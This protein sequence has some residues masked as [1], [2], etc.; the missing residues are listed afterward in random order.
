MWWTNDAIHTGTNQLKILW[1]VYFFSYLYFHLILCAYIT[2]L[3]DGI[4]SCM[5]SKPNFGSIESRLLFCCYYW[6]L[7]VSLVPQS[8]FASNKIEIKHQKYRTIG[9]TTICPEWTMQ[10]AKWC[11]WMMVYTFL[12]FDLTYGRWLTSAS[13]FTRSW[14][15]SVWWRKEKRN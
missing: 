7:L 12:L 14:T 11:N 2:F 10:W 3:I 9:Y 6:L 13:I 8:S 1:N 15:W 4:H 5:Q